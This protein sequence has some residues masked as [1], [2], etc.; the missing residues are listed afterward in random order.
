VKE[1]VHVKEGEKKRNAMWGERTFR[2]GPRPRVTVLSCSEKSGRESECV[3][4]RER[5]GECVFVCVRESV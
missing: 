4:V 2:N 3:C 5:G 1:L